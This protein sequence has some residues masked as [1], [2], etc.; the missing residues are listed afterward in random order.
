MSTC[1]AD[2]TERVFSHHM[3]AFLTKDLDATM[4]DYSDDSVVIIN[5]APGPVRGLAA[6]RAFFAQTF[7]LLTP[8]VLGSL[9][10]SCQVIEGENAYICYSAGTAIPFASDTFMVRGGK[11]ACQTVAVQ[12]GQTT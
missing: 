11:I 12:M 2:D 8:E 4:E 6:I 9:K 3:Q 10:T 7:G 5:T 1:R